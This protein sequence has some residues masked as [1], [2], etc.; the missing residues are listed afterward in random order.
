[1]VADRISTAA[2]T[3]RNQAKTD[4][5]NQAAEGKAHN[6]VERIIAFMKSFLD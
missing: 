6:C 4:T 3:N 5:Q 2:S 1:M